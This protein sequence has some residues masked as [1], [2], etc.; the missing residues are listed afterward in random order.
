MKEPLVNVNEGCLL[1]TVKNNI[2]GE[3]FYS[4]QGVPYAKPPLGN[5]RF[6]VSKQSKNTKKLVKYRLT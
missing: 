5:L 4:F 6:K 1:G 2:N 3:P